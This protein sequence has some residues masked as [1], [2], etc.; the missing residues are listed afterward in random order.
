M[1][2]V[3]L[4]V[5]LGGP[6]YVGP[7]FFPPV[8]FE[9]IHTHAV[10]KKANSKISSPVHAGTH[11]DAA[12]HSLPDGQTIDE[13]P[14]DR[15]IGRAVL[16]DLTKYTR[17]DTPIT[18]EQLIEVAPQVALRN[19]VVVLY[20]GWLADR[21][22]TQE[23]Y[24]HYPSLTT[25]A[26]QWLV[27]Q[28]VKAIAMDFAIDAGAATTREGGFGNHRLVHSAGIPIIENVANLDQLPT[29]FQFVGFPAKYYQGDGAPV[30]AV[31]IVDEPGGSHES[32]H[33]GGEQADSGETTELPP[34]YDPAAFAFFK[35]YFTEPNARRFFE[36]VR[37]KDEDFFRLW[38]AW[39]P[40]GMYSR[41]VIDQK[42][43]EMCAIAA[44]VALNA[45]PQVR[46]HV[47]GALYAGAT[48]EETLE[49]IL[50]QGVYAG[51]PYAIQALAMWDEAVAAYREGGGFSGL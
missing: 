3:D 2:I 15:F 34:S 9:P 40:A 29:E 13:M 35:R 37:T 25:E 44:S 45:L 17:P 41:T 16:I 32:T 21:Y 51:L 38:Q 6:D 18:L 30:R 43:R 48:Q 11:A 50:Q 1:K 19:K 14:L 20:S 42:T 33:G 23:Y 31:A 12:F 47:T 36:F 4:S 8:V 46:A 22:G 26:T 39:V 24:E 7:D 27:D 49:V 28:G 10:H 5:T